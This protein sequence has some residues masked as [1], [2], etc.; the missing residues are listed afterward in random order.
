MKKETTKKAVTKKAP[1]KKSCTKKTNPVKEAAKEIVDLT[2]KG[3]SEEELKKAVLNSKEVIDASRKKVK[4]TTIVTTVEL[5]VVTDK[6]FPAN[7][8][9]KSY[10]KDA[11]A[12]VVKIKDL[13]RELNTVDDVSI[14]TREDGSLAV[15]VFKMEE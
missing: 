5:T 13:L 14:V 7:K 2:M 1:V 8:S 6:K 10:E 11:Q 3:A 15:Q 12:L 9:Q 4:K